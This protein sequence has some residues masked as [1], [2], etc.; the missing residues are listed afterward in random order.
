MAIIADGKTNKEY[1]VENEI[2]ENTFNEVKE[3]MG[4][5]MKQY[6]ERGL[7]E[8]HLLSMVFSFKMVSSHLADGFIEKFG[9]EEVLKSLGATEIEK[10]ELN[11]KFELKNK[12]K[13]DMRMKNK[14]KSKKGKR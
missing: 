1:L 9:L 3:S 2:F 8:R 11:P 7:D 5:L 6:E 10:V 13:H 4:K 12:V 14:K